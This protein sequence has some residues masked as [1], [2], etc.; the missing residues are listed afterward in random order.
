M[1][2][3]TLLGKELDPELKEALVHLLSEWM[4]RLSQKQEKEHPKRNQEFYERIDN[5]EKMVK[6]TDPE[7][8][9]KNQEFLDWLI[10][11]YGD[12]LEEYYLSGLYDGIRVFRWMLTHEIKQ[13]ID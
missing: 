12:E 4:T 1:K 7:L 11:Y 6:E 9:R 2:I 8:A 3:E 5:W 10:G 13:I